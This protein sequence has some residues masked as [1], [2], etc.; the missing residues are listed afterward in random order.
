LRSKGAAAMKQTECTGEQL[1]F[2][3]LGRRELSVAFDGGHV[4]T[5]GGGL[6]LREVESRR[7]IVK[8]FSACFR[9]H[10]DPSRIEHSVEE[11]IRQRVMGMAL[12]YEDVIDHDQLR[13]DPLMSTLVERE[14]PTRALAGKSTLNRLELATGSS[15]DRYKKINWEQAAIDG[16]FVS[17]FLQAHEEEPERIVLDVDTTD[18]VLHGNQ[19]GRH[20][21]IHYGEYCYLPLYIVCGDHVLCARLRSAGVD[22]G[23]GALEDLQRIVMQ[24]RQSWPRVMITIRGDSGFCRDEIMT[25]CEDNE[26]S[27]VLGLPKNPRLMREIAEELAEAERESERTGEKAKIYTNFSYQTQRSWTNPR[28]VVAKAEHFGGQANPRFVVTSLHPDVFDAKSVY[29]V[30]YSG[31]GDMENRIKEQKCFMF[32]DR[33]SAATMRANQLRLWFSAVA[34]MLMTA[35]RRDGLKETELARAQCDTIR[36]KL[37]KIGARV[38]VTTRKMWISLSSTYPFIQ[39]FRRVLSNLAHAAP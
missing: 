1:K 19:E 34:Y 32:A 36:L 12:G 20:Y 2:Q 10:R 29:E 7:K 17:V 26:V 37:F 4:S 24:I 38:R 21:L 22:P 16:F 33:M 8:Q 11:M 39:L 31:R 28:R 6:L 35:L 18:A 5:D 30:E 3:G 27:F 14:D 9:D 23:K 25:W 13:D 15:D